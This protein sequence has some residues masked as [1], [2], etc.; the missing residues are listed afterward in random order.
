MK[1]HDPS[2]ANNQFDAQVYE[3]EVRII[4]GI[5]NR[6]LDVPNGTNM[7]N[8]AHETVKLNWKKQ[9]VKGSKFPPLILRYYR[10]SLADFNTNI[11]FRKLLH[12][13]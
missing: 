11:T 9:E 8:L 5:E 6:T 2:R 1:N 12:I 4:E 10:Y 13:F 7:N 3:L